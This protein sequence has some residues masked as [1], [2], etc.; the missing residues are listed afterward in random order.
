MHQ[1]RLLCAGHCNQKF[2]VHLCNPQQVEYWSLLEELRTQYQGVGSSEL[3]LEAEAAPPLQEQG[4]AQQTAAMAQGSDAGSGMRSM[5]HAARSA[6]L[7]VNQHEPG[8]QVQLGGAVTGTAMYVAA[9][10]PSH[11]SLVCDF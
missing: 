4:P 9:T 8:A 3:A 1:P 2:S 11:L 10:P 7:E 6:N 5:M